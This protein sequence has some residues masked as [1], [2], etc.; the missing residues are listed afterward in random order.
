MLSL[1]KLPDGRQ[2]VRINY[3]SLDLMQTCMR[4][5]HYVLNESLVSEHESDALIFGTAVHKALETWYGLPC[6]E[7]AVKSDDKRMADFYEHRQMLEEPQRGVAEALRQFTKAALPLQF[8][9]GEKR[10]IANGLKILLAYFKHY[11]NDGLEILRDQGGKPMT[12]VSFS[13]RMQESPF[14]V[15]EYFGTIDC[16]LVA[17]DGDILPFDH[18]TTSALGTEFFNRVKPNHQYTGYVMGA[19]KAL[20]LDVNALCV[21]GIQ[22]A[23]T[24]HEFAR[25]TTVRTEDDFQELEQAV[26][27]MVNSWLN[28]I[29]FPMT[30]P[31]PCAQYGG[32]QF[33]DLCSAPKELREGIKK[34]KWNL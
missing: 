30:T 7:R 23:K 12:E 21:N 19:R 5:A 15:I 24:K 16:I 14:L 26:I 2:L 1:S 10:G 13:F 18:K 32:C 11:E 20:G 17:Q 34:V 6:S 9:E 4:K 31:G 28:R 3:S 25:Q 33:L 27:V 29:N 22:V 8:L